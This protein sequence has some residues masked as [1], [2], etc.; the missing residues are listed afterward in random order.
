MTNDPGSGASVSDLTGDSPRQGRVAGASFA[1]RAG[2]RIQSVLDALTRR[3]ENRK[4]EYTIWGALLTALIAFT[5]F[6]PLYPNYDTYYA[7]IWGNE[8]AHGQLPDYS[9]FNTPT[10]HPL[11]NAYTAVLSLFG[12]AA[13]PLLVIA[14]LAMYVGLLIGVYRMVQLKIGTL[15]AFVSVLV[16]LTRT[17]LIAFAFRAMLDIPFLAMII[18]AAVLELKRPRRGVAPLVLLAMAGLLRPEAWL[19]AGMY[20][21]WLALGVVRPKL[22]LPG[23]TPSIGRLA[24]YAGL[25]VGAPLIWLGFDWIVTGDPMYSISSTREVAAGLNRQKSL[26]QSIWLLPRLIGGS[27]QIV[28]AIAGTLGLG[29]AVYVLRARMLILVGLAATGV[30]TYLL[31]A[32]AGLSVISRYLVIPSIVMCIGVAFALSGWAQLSGPARRAGVGLAAIALLLIAVRAPAY[33]HQGQKLNTSTNHVSVRFNR[34]YK[35]LEKPAIRAK[36]ARCLPVVAFTHETVPVIRYMLDLPKDQVPTTTQLDG[37]PTGGTLLIPTSALD[38]LQLTV[39]DRALRKPWT[40][41]PQPG[42]EFEGENRAWI[43]YTK[44][45]SGA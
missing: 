28:N 1:A 40:G 41:L 29:L 17:D 37:P 20:W 42:F 10:P 34:I 36:V 3:L 30:L 14:S 39:V 23:E 7:L 19:L 43:V 21:L 26:P 5:I 8:I 11:F 38:P 31:I 2:R 12:G 44:C 15:V 45:G 6:R 22:K 9:V 35:I 13:I 27:E 16:L 25:V 18:W 24:G 32:I 4:V 33:V